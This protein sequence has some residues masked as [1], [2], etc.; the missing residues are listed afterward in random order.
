MYFLSFFL[1]FFISSNSQDTNYCLLL[2]IIY[3]LVYICYEWPSQIT[4]AL[5]II[6]II[7]KHAN[8]DG[9]TLYNKWNNKFGVI[10]KKNKKSFKKQNII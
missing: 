1:C 10:S 9:Q 8:V 3:F 4:S 6:I 2:Y 5:I 7:V